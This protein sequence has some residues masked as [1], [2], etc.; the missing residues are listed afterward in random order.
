MKR[1]LLVLL[2]LSLV[3][4]PA[5]AQVLRETPCRLYDSRNIGGTGL[6]SKVSS[7]TIDTWGTPGASQGGESG[8]GVPYGSSAVIVSLTVYQPTSAGYARLWRTGSTEPLSTSISYADNET[9]E[10]TGLPVGVGLTNGRMDL[11]AAFGTAHFIVD[12]IGWHEGGGGGSEGFPAPR[13]FRVLIFINAPVA[14]LSGGDRLI[15]QDA[16]ANPFIGHDDEIATWKGIP[17]CNPSSAAC[18]EFVAPGDGD[19]AFEAAGQKY[20]RYR[21][22]GAAGWFLDSP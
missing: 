11:H 4:F 5:A 9:D 10:S 17:S 16:T 21:A 7:A 18:W 19:F 8:C 6:G 20:W 3:S 1:S 12:L 13:H 22:L 14:G 15:V 2:V